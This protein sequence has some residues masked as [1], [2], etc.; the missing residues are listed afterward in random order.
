MTSP[1]YLTC[2]W[3]ASGS[4]L[5]TCLGCLA[6]GHNWALLLSTVPVVPRSYSSCDCHI[7]ITKKMSKPTSTT[8][9]DGG[10]KTNLNPPQSRTMAM[11]A[12]SL[13]A[14]PLVASVAMLSLIFGGCCSN[15]G[16][17][18]SHRLCAT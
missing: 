4:Q 18:D 1:K 10:Q 17:R 7:H 14:S 6:E 3:M 16:H 5:S 9:G 12:V 13:A 2:S 8:P 15:V 11:Q